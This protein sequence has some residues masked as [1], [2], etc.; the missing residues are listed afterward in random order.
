MTTEET[1]RREFE[2]WAEKNGYDLL[3]TKYAKDIYRNA[4]TRWSWEAWQAAREKF[5]NLHR[6]EII[7][8][9]SEKI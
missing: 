9:A 1:N 5:N 6:Y 3:P 2:E 8:P 7:P 4:N